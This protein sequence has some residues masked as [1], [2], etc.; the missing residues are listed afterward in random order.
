MDFILPLVQRPSRLR[1]T[2][3]TVSR[4]PGPLACSFAHSTYTR[5]AAVAK[6]GSWGVIRFDLFH[7]GRKNLVKALSFIRHFAYTVL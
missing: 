4:V 7:V 3:S 2:H 1:V 6:Y 5:W